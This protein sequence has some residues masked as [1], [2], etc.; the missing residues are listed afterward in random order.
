MSGENEPA[1][2][3]EVPERNRGSLTCEE[4]KGALE[5]AFPD[6]HER[7]WVKEAWAALIKLGLADYSNEMERYEA[8]IR[9]I[10]FAGFYKD[11]QAQTEEC[12]RA[13]NYG[14]ILADLNL[15]S[16]RLGQLIG[17]RSD[18]LDDSNF[19][20]YMSLNID[21][22]LLQRAMFHLE[23]EARPAVVTSPWLRRAEHGSSSQHTWIH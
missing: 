3:P 8:A 13:F 16:F 20:P 6:A 11:W 22:Q 19:D 1:R 10:A 15:T 14:E 2:A 9:F 17:R 4:V 23:L 7:L 21:E 5:R 18:F 12:D